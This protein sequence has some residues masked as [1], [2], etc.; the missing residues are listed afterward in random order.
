MPRYLADAA[1]SGVSDIRVN[2]VYGSGRHGAWQFVAHLTWRQRDGSVGGGIV[3]LPQYAG[4]PAADSPFTAGRLAN[5]ER[6]GWTLPQLRDRTTGLP[7][8]DA[9]L[10][11]LELEITP[12]NDGTLTFCSATRIG[13]A[14]CIGEMRDGRRRLFT[15]NVALSSENGPLSVHRA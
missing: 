9:T 8:T 10:A 13:S 6:A 4:A 11:L 15:A 12:S 7:G 2:G 3:S 1:G 14:R 5:E